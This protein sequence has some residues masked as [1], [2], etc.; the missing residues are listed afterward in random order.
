[1]SSKDR[2]F[3]VFAFFIITIFSGLIAF[4]ITLFSFSSES[5]LGCFFKYD[6]LYKTSVI[7]LFIFIPSGIS[8]VIIFYS[9]FYSKNKNADDRKRI[10]KRTLF[11][12]IMFTIIISLFISAVYPVL[13]RKREENINYTILARK[14]LDEVVKN[15]NNQNYKEAKNYL[16]IYINIDKN[17]EAR[18]NINRDKENY[19]ISLIPDDRK[20]KI[21]SKR[22]SQIGLNP[23]NLYLEIEELENLKNKENFVVLPNKNDYFSFKKNAFDSFSVATSS[24]DF[25]KMLEA[26]SLSLQLYKMNILDNEAKELYKLCYENVVQNAFFFE[27]LDSIKNLVLSEN[28]SFVNYKDEDRKEIINIKKIVLLN[29]SIFGIDNEIITYDKD[30]KI[31][32]SIYAK[33]GK[34]GKDKISFM[35]IEKGSG[36]FL[37]T[38]KVSNFDDKNVLSAKLNIDPVLIPFLA[39]GSSDVKKLN[40]LQLFKI[41]KYFFDRNDVIKFINIEIIFKIVLNLSFFLIPL[42]AML[43]G[44]VFSLEKIDNHFDGWFF[45]PVIIFVVFVFLLLYYLI[46]RSI[47][48]ILV[49]YTNFYLAFIIPVV[50]I[51]LL[52]YLYM[53]RII[54]RF[55]RL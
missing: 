33:F 11:L 4:L 39:K 2:F 32:K 3:Q 51:V 26:Y 24:K 23:D 35:S 7:F 49:L 13:E 27:E 54:I 5:L 10:F 21:F 19:T 31:L 29:N 6:I 38:I 18:F 14:C 55:S 25:Y 43:L 46:L 48:T 47:V 16:R 44:I 17:W 9:I 28:I 45:I 40:L 34:M 1:M 8:F 42:I 36:K 37:N 50:V 30:G 20:R 12:N 41:K 22:R 15:Y 52:I 53:T